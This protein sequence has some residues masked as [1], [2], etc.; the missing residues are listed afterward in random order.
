M[1]ERE[2]RSRY[3]WL[4]DELTRH[5]YLY[6]VLDTPEIEDDAYDALMRE[7]LAIEKKHP[8]WLRGDSPSQR[9]GGAPLEAFAKVAHEKPM[10]SLE[11]VF[12]KEEL[13]DWL[14]RAC[15]GVEQ[16]WIPWCC[17]LKIDGLAVSLV[18][19][20]G[21]FV[22]ASTRGD[23]H[24][25]EDVTENLKTVRDLPLRLPG[26]MSGTLELRGEV[27]MSK[28]GFAKL[29]AEREEAGLPLF[30]N[31][32]NAAA[33]S[34]RQLDPAIAAKR[35]LRLF[36]YYI[37]D[38]ENLGLT[39]QSDILNWLKEKG[40]PVQYAWSCAATQADIADFIDMWSDQ[41]HSL[42]YATDGVVLKADCQRYWKILGQNVKTPKWAVAYKYPPEEQRTRLESIEI[43]LGRTG[44]LTPVAN[45]TPVLI[46]GTVV[47]RAS[48]H[49]EDEI[50]RKDI[51]VGDLVWV[52]K[53]GEIIPEIVRVDRES[54]DG[55]EEPFLMPTAC[56]VCGA[57][58]VK[59][60]DEAALRCPNRSCPAQL[61]QGLIHFASRQ[62]MNIQGLGDSLAE[63]LVQT[64]LV[65]KFSDLY[66]LT[67][68]SL[69]ALKRMGTKSAEKIVAAIQAS[70][71]RPLKFLLTALGIR[72]VGYGVAQELARTFKTLDEIA[73]AD[74]E[75]LASVGGVGSV[76]AQSIKNFFSEPHNIAMIE[77][78]RRAGV[79]MESDSQG[80][81][82]TLLAGKTF[83]F[84]GELSRMTRSEA[85]ALVTGLG[86][87]AASSVSKKT[88]FVVEG[89]DAG[90]KAEK[91]RS[92][93]VPLLNEE[94][95]MKMINE[96]TQS[97]SE[98]GGNDNA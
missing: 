89:A 10:L 15:D 68:Q 80:S 54:R 52:R 34:L 4:V 49:N 48:L 2:E 91:A 85:Q 29:N 46:S 70:K 72:E 23:G 58:V 87:K 21:K 92:L 25:G 7:L 6:Y 37:Q 77:E 97:Q 8:G 60:A 18:Y 79:R 63:Q 95:F 13:F 53:A 76:I 93:G 50:Q 43:S 71:Q 64:G 78:L 31:P 57:S 26:E 32:R 83:V 33:G 9:T 41:R 19:Q 22:Q 94:D 59:F 17:E 65:K 35:R 69:A 38:A 39:S 82:L 81:G 5:G 44:V 42:P 90:S 3:D 56:P 88:S 1:D 28:E 36:V 86:G 67:P 74:E 14:K 30:A 61:V 45:L 62:G 16:T 96:L 20:D 84:T 66:S 12:S 73:Q 40:F 51:R 98:S 47:K 27:Y 24:I 55:T 75:K 11:D